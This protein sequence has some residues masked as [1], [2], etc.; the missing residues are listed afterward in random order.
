MYLTLSHGPSGAVVTGVV[1]TEDILRCFGLYPADPPPGPGPAPLPAH[2]VRPSVVVCHTCGPL[3]R[4]W[5]SGRQ[6][7]RYGP[8]WQGHPPLLPRRVGGGWADLDV[9]DEVHEADELVVWQDR[10]EPLR[11]VRR[12]RKVPAS[13]RRRRS[14]A[15]RR[16]PQ[17]VRPPPASARERTGARC[18]RSPLGPCSPGGRGEQLLQ[19]RCCRAA[20]GSASECHEQMEGGYKQGQTAVQAR[21]NCG[22]RGDARHVKLRAGARVNGRGGGGGGVGWVG[23]RGVGG[24]GVT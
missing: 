3:R 17:S 5:T 21:S 12:L 7:G 24:G 2:L 6:S 1:V 23:W 22:G 8:R 15:T 10:R 9:L 11:P 16:S 4:I 18:E 13:A 19:G 14:A 20:C